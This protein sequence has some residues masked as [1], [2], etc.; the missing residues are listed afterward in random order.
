MLPITVPI[1][2]VFAIAVPPALRSFMFPRK[3]DDTSARTINSVGLLETEAGALA[4]LAVDGLSLDL[5][6]EAPP[7]ICR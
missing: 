1:T 3:F 5:E 6:N 2:F 4:T 7:V